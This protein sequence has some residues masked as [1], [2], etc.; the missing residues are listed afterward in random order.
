M[1]S[2]NLLHSVVGILQASFRIPAAPCLFDWRGVLAVSSL[3]R[4]IYMHGR[5]KLYTVTELKKPGRGS[6][7]SVPNG[8]VIPSGCIKSRYARSDV[9][10]FGDYTPYRS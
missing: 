8:M 5:G 10:I 1:L 7:G 9:E 6:L 3:C 4:S 2:D